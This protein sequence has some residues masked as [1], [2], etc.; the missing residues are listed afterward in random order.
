MTGPTRGLQTAEEGGA[1]EEE[2]ARLAHE[3]AVCRAEREE[4][5][6]RLEAELAE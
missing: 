3:L 4:E 2:A 5:A 1:Q 6:A